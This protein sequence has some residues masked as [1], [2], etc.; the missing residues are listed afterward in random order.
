MDIISPRVNNFYENIKIA[1]MFIKAT[2][3]DLNKVKRIRTYALRCNLH[4]YFL[5]KQ[6]LL[7]SDKK[8]ADVS[9]SQNVFHVIYI[10][11]GSSLGKVSLCQVS[12]L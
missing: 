4:L 12:T 5:I 7:I 10:F 1:T 2:F 8:N 6:K 3:K 9:R 11:L